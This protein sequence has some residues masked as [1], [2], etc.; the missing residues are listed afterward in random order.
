MSPL[1]GFHTPAWDGFRQRPG[2][3]LAAKWAG[4]RL[5]FPL[6]SLTPL[7]F[8][9]TSSRRWAVDAL[10]FV[11]MGHGAYAMVTACSDTNTT[12]PM[13]HGAGNK[14]GALGGGSIFPT[15]KA[16]ISCQD[17]GTAVSGRRVGVNAQC[18]AGYSYVGF[19]A[20]SCSLRLQPSK[21][22]GAGSLD[23]T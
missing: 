2:L 17:G 9:W 5:G 23:E 19:S 21:P 3:N 10:V 20:W 16:D 4:S 15:V 6:T 8:F 12:M 1:F 13:S 14:Y 22:A 18:A 11:M 7:I